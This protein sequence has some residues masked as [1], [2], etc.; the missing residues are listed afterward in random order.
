M[1]ENKTGHFPDGVP[2][3]LRSDVKGRKR[4]LLEVLSN[5]VTVEI[6]VEDAE[7]GQIEVKLRSPSMSKA[8]EMAAAWN[9]IRRSRNRR[10]LHTRVL[11]QER[12]LAVKKGLALHEAPSGVEGK[13]IAQAF[14]ELEETDDINVL[15]MQHV[16]DM[17]W[18][19]WSEPMLENG[20]SLSK[21]HIGQLLRMSGYLTSPLLVALDEVTGHEFHMVDRVIE[22]D[23]WN[24][25]YY[26]IGNYA[27]QVE[28]PERV[29][30]DALSKLEQLQAGS[31]ALEPYA[32]PEDQEGIASLA[33]EEQVPLG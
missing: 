26:G 31:A 20:E 22:Q 29:E 10:E 25:L 30:A 17:L 24:R 3:S 7:G 5:G 14:R 1:T 2:R 21:D 19:C 28:M 16:V 23:K 9:E 33:K 18:V 13:S 27:K 15:F 32:Q 8:M 6:P 12:A 4:N 11:E